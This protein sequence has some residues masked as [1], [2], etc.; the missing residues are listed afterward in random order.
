[1][2]SLLQVVAAIHATVIVDAVQH[3]EHVAYFMDYHFASSQQQNIV[4]LLFGFKLLPSERW[5]LPMD[6]RAPA[7]VDRNGEA[8]HVAQIVSCQVELHQS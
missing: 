6:T 3:S 1:M 8:E 5:E 4:R 7:S 2:V